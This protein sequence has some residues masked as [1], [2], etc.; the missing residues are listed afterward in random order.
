VI[1]VSTELAHDLEDFL[2]IVYSDAEFVRAEFEAIVA[3]SWDDPPARPPRRD[4]PGPPSSRRRHRPGPPCLV[5]GA[6]PV[7][8]S[9]GSG[10]RQRGPP[11]TCAARETNAGDRGS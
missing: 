4:R 9:G 2:D 10:G 7:W 1:L 3:A 5:P 11:L 8:G 6:L